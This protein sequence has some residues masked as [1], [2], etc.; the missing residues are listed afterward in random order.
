MNRIW[1]RSRLYK[2]A[3]MLLAL[4]L[5]SEQI[6]VLKEL[7]SYLLDSQRERELPQHA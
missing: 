4:L 6:V 7:R 2:S 3:L 1:Q 5:V